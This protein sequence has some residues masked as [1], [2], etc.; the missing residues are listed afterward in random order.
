MRLHK[1]AY[2]LWEQDECPA[3]CADEY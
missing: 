1:R 2:F 3:G